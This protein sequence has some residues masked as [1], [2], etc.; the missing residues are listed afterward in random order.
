MACMWSMV[1][2][3]RCPCIPGI[4]PGAR[5]RGST[6]RVSQPTRHLNCQPG[7]PGASGDRWTLASLGNA[8]RRVLP[9]GGVPGVLRPVPGQ[10][11]P[12]CGRPS[13]GESLRGIQPSPRP[14]Q[15]SRLRTVDIWVGKFSVVGPAVHRGMF[16]A[17]PAPCATTLV[18]SLLVL[19][20]QMPPAIAKCPPVWTFTCSASGLGLSWGQSLIG[21]G[22]TDHGAA[23]LCAWLGVEALGTLTAS[24]ARPC[25]WGSGQGR[26][27]LPLPLR[28]LD[29]NT[30]PSY[31]QRLVFVSVVPVLGARSA[32]P[33][34]GICGVP[35]LTPNPSQG[36]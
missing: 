34:A 24:K 7:W 13:L 16:R 26:T 32:S 21:Q 30:V 28:C 1:R 4:R 20:P 15:A 2:Y 14:E 17:S 11:P 10:G 19:R 6:K 9:R 27:S 23:Q 8:A 25:L 31:S 12:P 22:N 3:R 18:A 33:E 35:L 36:L 29:A 5:S